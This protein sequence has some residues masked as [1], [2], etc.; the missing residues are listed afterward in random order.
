MR[1]SLLGKVVAD[2]GAGMSLVEEAGPEAEV[3]L[4]NHAAG[5]VGFARRQQFL[6]RLRHLGLLP[7]E[8]PRNRQIVPLIGGA[9]G[10]HAAVNRVAQSHLGNLERRVKRLAKGNVPKVA[11]QREYRGGS[12]LPIGIDPLCG[13]DG[14][15]LLEE[16]RIHACRSGST[17]APSRRSPRKSFLGRS[18]QIG[19]GV[20]SFSERDMAERVPTLTPR[21]G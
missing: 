12:I 3:H 20:S 7:E 13:E 14:L 4:G 19:A 21:T 5:G 16:R 18:R 10:L 2:A 11:S 1:E 9:T 8:E 15:E 6:T 17:G